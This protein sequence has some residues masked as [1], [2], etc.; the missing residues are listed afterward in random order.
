[1]HPAIL[2]ILA[3]SKFLFLVLSHLKLSENSKLSFVFN[4]ILFKLEKTF[5]FLLFRATRVACGSSLARG[6]IGAAAAGLHHSHSNAGSKPCLRPTPQL[7]A[8][9][10][11]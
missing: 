6:Q 7:M 2:F 4:L 8:P 5:F 10:G 1:M 9:P 11:P 3:L